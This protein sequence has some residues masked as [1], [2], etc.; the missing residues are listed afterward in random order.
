VSIRFLRNTAAPSPQKLKV[1]VSASGWR[2]FD[3]AHHPAGLTSTARRCGP[4]T[5]CGCRCAGS[6]GNPHCSGTPERTYSGTVGR[7][8]RTLD[9]K[10]R[11]M[12]VELDVWNQDGSLAPGMYATVKWTVQRKRPALF[13]PKTSVVT[14]TERALVIREQAGRVHCRSGTEW[15]LRFD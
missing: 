15:M 14:T 6:Q 11:T 5:E 8:A 9:Q 12:A 7:I 13:V 10:T 2:R 4:R 3:P 1:P